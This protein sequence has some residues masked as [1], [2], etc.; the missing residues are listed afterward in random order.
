[1][2]STLLA[3]IS[4]LFVSC[5]SDNE[6]SKPVDYTV[7]NEKE[8]VDYI[9]KNKLTATKTDSGLYYVVN[10]AGTGAQPTASS[11]VTVAYKG[12]FTNGNVFD[13]SDASGISFG[14][15]QVIKGWTEGIPF[16]KEGGSGVLLIPSHLGY[17]SNGSGPIPAGSVLVFNVKLI[18]VN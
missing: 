6:A 11:N 15:N 8:I 16:F 7:Q 14:L 4:L 3:L 2:K 17:G 9:A 18:K 12:Y 10:E 5:L 13:Q 1:M